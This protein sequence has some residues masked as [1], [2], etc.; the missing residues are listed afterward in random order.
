MSRRFFCLLGL[1]NISRD[2]ALLLGC[3]VINFPKPK[4]CQILEIISHFL[5]VGNLDMAGLGASDPCRFFSEDCNQGLQ[6]SLES[7]V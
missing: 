5:L 6:G 7:W 3:C 2:G 4:L 1:S